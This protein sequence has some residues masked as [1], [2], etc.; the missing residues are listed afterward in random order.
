MGS[1][2][3][4]LKSLTLLSMTQPTVSALGSLQSLVLTDQKESLV[5]KDLL[6]LEELT[7]RK[8]SPH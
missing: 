4:S 8:L 6:T 1:I 2:S 3:P 7:V 5:I